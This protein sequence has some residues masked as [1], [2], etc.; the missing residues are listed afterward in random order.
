MAGRNYYN[1][2]AETIDCEEIGFI[3]AAT[4]AE[5]IKKVCEMWDVP[6][7]AVTVQF[8]EIATADGI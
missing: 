7:W 6:A 5:A 1:Y 4:E 3:H 2:V 8:D